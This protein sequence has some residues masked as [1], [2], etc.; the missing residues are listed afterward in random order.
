MDAKEWVLKEYDGEDVDKW[1]FTRVD[2]E[3]AF[4]AG[5]S[6]YRNSVI[7][8]LEIIQDML[9]DR[10]S[11]MMLGVQMVPQI[12]QMFNLLMEKIKGD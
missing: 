1:V 12:S 7:S 8:P 6:E 3:Q 9:N 10:K 2:M 4:K 5:M 11:F